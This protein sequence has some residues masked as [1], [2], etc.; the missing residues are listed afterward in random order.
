MD[1]IQIKEK[2]IHKKELE[3]IKESEERYKTLFENAQVGMYRT[4]PDGEII[5]VNPRLLEILG[6]SSLEELRSRN[7]EDEGFSENSPRSRFKELL[8][9]NG[10]VKNFESTWEKSD[11]TE[12]YI[13]ENARELK[14]EE[15]KVIYYDGTVEDIT[16][17]K[18]AI[19]KVEEQAKLLDIAT[20]A[21]FVIDLNDRILFWNKSCEKLYGW[22]SEK[23]IGKKSSEL[24]YRNENLREFDKASSTTKDKSEWTGELKHYKKDGEIIDV[25]S[26]WTLVLN[27]SGKPKS[28]F[29]V[30]SDITEKKKM[31]AQFLRAQRMQSIGT[32]AGGIAHDLNNMLQPITMSL[33]ILK[34][35]QKDDKT[36]DLINIIESS[37][38]RSANL[39][40][41]VLSFA[42]G[43]DGEFT[44][45]EI[46][47][48]ISEIEKIIN[49]T[50]PKSISFSKKLPA[51]LWTVSGDT[52]QL[53]QVFMNLCV[54]ARDAM[55]NGGNI[56]ITG[57]NIVV[58]KSFA[59][60]NIGA[61]S[62]PHIAISVSDNG[63]G[64]PPKVLDRIFEPFFTTKGAEK[65]TGLGLSTV[66]G[67]V[68]GHGGFVNVESEMG[69]GSTFR[70]YLPANKVQESSKLPDKQKAELPLGNGELILLVD[71]EKNILEIATITLKTYGYNVVTAENGAEATAIYARRQNDISA[72][73][74]DMMMP[75]MDGNA[76][77]N[78]INTL[79]PDA[80]II[81]VSGLKNSSAASSLNEEAGKAVRAFLSKPYKTETLLKTLSEILN[82]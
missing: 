10:E 31:E 64:I 37:S 13:R 70:I 52:T 25:E 28:I 1:D 74:V 50:F 36:L 14:N 41:Q 8:K 3:R 51:K 71:D 77:I 73:L 81:A 69:T 75:V 12:V 32:L 67:I 38:K 17:L 15:G 30:N 46:K 82:N 9:L 72:V 53:N 57:E 35:T 47:Y 60:M 22:S 76:T 66:F 62:G 49:E 16:N 7:L 26:R 27:N 21:I 56:S 39:V 78:A 34:L 58:D 42:K 4:T 11:G 45:I 24:I 79:N 44:T 65:G 63:T 80:H 43:I 29:V 6:F 59:G 48:I 33:E 19:E 23:A 5:M 40:K 54:N 18:L 2:N 61:K 55:P 20:D 68:K